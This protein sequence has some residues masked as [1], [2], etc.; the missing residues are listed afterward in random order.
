MNN[1][2]ILLLA[3]LSAACTSLLSYDALRF[4]TIGPFTATLSWNSETPQTFVVEYGEGDLLDRQVEDKE[5]ST[6]H[7][8]TLTG[9]KPATRY[10]Y[11]L[12]KHDKIKYFRTAP[13]KDG[14]FDLIVLSTS[15]PACKNQDPFTSSRP[16]IIANLAPQ[17]CSLDENASTG[18]IKNLSGETVVRFN[19]GRYEIVLAADTVSL[20][21]TIAERPPSAGAPLL[22]I[23][24]AIPEYD[25]QRDENV[26]YVSDRAY[27]YR[28]RAATL[29][30][31][32]L[33]WLEI[34]A[35][36]V[37]QVHGVGLERMREVIIAAPPE[38]K[39]SCL[40]CNRLLEAGRYLESLEWYRTFIREN[41]ERHAVEDAYYSLARILD[42]KLFDYPQAIAAYNDFMAR[43]P[44]SRRTIL[45]KYRLDY[46]ATHADNDYFPLRRFE[47]VKS[48]LVRD[49][50]MPTVLEVEKLVDAFPQSSVTAE[51]LYWLGHIL[52]QT[53]AVR[54]QAHYRTLI[55]RFPQSENAA[56]A[57]IAL[58]DIHYR[59]K[60]YRQAITAY[61]QALAVVPA[62]FHLS[63]KDKLRKS[64]RNIGREQNRYAAWMILG[65]WLLLSFFWRVIPSKRDWLTAIVVLTLFGFAGG[66]FFFLTYERTN[67]LLPPVAAMATGTSALVLWNNALA[68]MS[69]RGRMIVVMAHALTAPPA[70]LFLLLYH[71]HQLYVFGL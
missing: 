13:G 53:D 50:V 60:E 31:N 28:E 65:G 16:D 58:G 25:A 67:I 42:E 39:K 32:Q 43:Y 38:T 36:E 57:A 62:N 29:T 27:R 71:F 59:A 69:R 11:R 4:E 26:L 40:F 48:A 64:D 3:L 41:E 6:R 63:V 61:N 17:Q 15:S 46:L 52:E 37:A 9:L 22:A 47:Q 19:Y 24:P 66:L 14:V 56:M 21:R 5:K 70:M 23:G 8:L 12:H 45:I 33:M 7:Q 20:G 54:A 49:N 10:G 35:F 2:A 18:L 55:D 34:D 44:D 1:R 51:A 30:E 68:G